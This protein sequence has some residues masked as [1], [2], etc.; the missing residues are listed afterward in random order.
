TD[1]DLLRT[2][3]DD[4]AAGGIAQAINS[5]NLS[6]TKRLEPLTSEQQQ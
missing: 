4:D 6:S 3:D 2:T 1:D 5:F